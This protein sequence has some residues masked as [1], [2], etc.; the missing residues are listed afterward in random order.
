MNSGSTHRLR[1]NL[2]RPIHQPNSVLHARETEASTL[3]CS[4]P[5][6]TLFLNRSRPDES[7]P[8]LPSV[9]LRS[10]PHRC[11]SAHCAMLLVTPETGKARLQMAEYW[12][13]HL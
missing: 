10:V 13:P 4:F 2:N 3:H 8:S 9:A 1:I 6:R 11:A 12:I 5:N 7:H